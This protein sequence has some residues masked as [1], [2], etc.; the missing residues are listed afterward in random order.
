MSVIFLPVYQ[1]FK[2]KTSTRGMSYKK[3]S[4]R[5]WPVS[6]VPYQNI[7]QLWSTKWSFLFFHWKLLLC[8]FFSKVSLVTK[9]FFRGGSST[10]KR[11]HLHPSI[12]CYRCIAPV[13]MKNCHVSGPCGLIKG[14]VLC[15]NVVH[16][17]IFGIRGC[18]HYLL[19]FHAP[20]LPSPWRRPCNFVR[21]FL[22][23][24]TFIHSP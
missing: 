11:V 19:K 15:K 24:H 10:G 6:S 22:I 2:V 4:L 18:L 14:T 1:V 12:L 16:F 17:S 5:F 20:V 13:L 23:T 8:L 3:Q 21:V 7:F 9:S